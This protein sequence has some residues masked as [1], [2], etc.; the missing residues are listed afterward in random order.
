MM[1][2]FADI[3]AAGRPKAAPGSAGNACDRRLPDKGP[4][5][6]L[7]IQIQYDKSFQSQ[8]ERL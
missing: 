8:A 7:S 2:V 1:L 4:A 5:G 3:A 6:V